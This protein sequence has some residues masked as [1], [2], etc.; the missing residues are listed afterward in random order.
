MGCLGVCVGGG[1]E[2]GEGGSWGHQK[3]GV[4]FWIA[5]ESLC[6]ICRACALQ[7][8][9]NESICSLCFC[10]ER[11]PTYQKHH[12]TNASWSLA[13]LVPIAAAGEGG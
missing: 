1:E 11:G 10:L 2:A 12:N 3:T 9:E 13:L 5:I 6:L 8:H 7:M 4:F